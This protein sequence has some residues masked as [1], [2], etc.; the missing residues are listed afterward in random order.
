MRHCASALVVILALLGW[1]VPSPGLALDRDALEEL[2]AVIDDQGLL[3]IESE[4]RPDALVRLGQ[5]LFFD[6]E[7]SGNRD[8]SC[9]TCHHPSLATGDGL[10]VSIGTGGAGLGPDRSLG[11]DRDLIPRNAPDVFNRG[12]AD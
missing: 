11:D 7:L 2:R 1:L 10:A 5:A 6:R 4:D 9:A 8:V 3:P 12:A